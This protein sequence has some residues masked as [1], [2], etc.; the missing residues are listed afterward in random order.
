MD[1]L[2]EYAEVQAE[3]LCQDCS[4]VDYLGFECDYVDDDEVFPSEV[5]PD[6]G[7]E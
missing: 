4:E 2:Y 7:V 3:M 5:Y 1:L 6:I